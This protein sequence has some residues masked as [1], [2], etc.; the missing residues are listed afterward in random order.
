MAPPATPPIKSPIKSARVV[1]GIE[2]KLAL[3]LIVFAAVIPILAVA[4]WGRPGT[5]ADFL[6]LLFVGVYMFAVITTFAIILLWGLGRLDLPEKFMHWLG[7]ATIG[8]V[9]GLLM[10]VVKKVFAG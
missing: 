7:A 9:A 6:T 2:T 3:G 5:L 4:W 10:F 1:T 8:E